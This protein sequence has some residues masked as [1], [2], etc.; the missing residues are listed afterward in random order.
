MKELLNALKAIAAT[1][2]GPSGRWTEQKSDFGSLGMLK[3]NLPDFALKVTKNTR[4][5]VF[6]CYKSLVLSFIL[7]N[8]SRN[9]LIM[10]KSSSC[11]KVAPKFWPRTVSKIN[12]CILA[13][14]R[15]CTN[16]NDWVLLKKQRD[17]DECTII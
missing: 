11:A 4:F 7:I 10:S 12:D 8:K 2:G 14:E 1:D 15:F 13:T 5:G 17:L 6:R 9:L 16:V 3:T